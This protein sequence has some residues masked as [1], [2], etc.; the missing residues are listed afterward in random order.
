MTQTQSITTRI[1]TNIPSIGAI[2]CIA[3]CAANYFFVGGV[4]ISLRATTFLA[5]TIPFAY[6][7]SN[8]FLVLLWVRQIMRRV[9]GWWYTRVPA[10]ITYAAVTILSVFLPARQNDP[11]L[12]LFY[13]FFGQG[14]GAGVVLMCCIS[15]IMGYL[16]VYVARTTLRAL[17]LIIAIYVILGCAG[18]YNFFGSTLL[19]NMMDWFQGYWIGIVEYMA[20][21]VYHI[22]Q[23]ALVT[24]VILLQERLRPN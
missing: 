17:M 8:T 10:I 2:A 9:P 5:W 15:M 23:I 7:V 24:R 1:Y 12:V 4:P 11:Y 18:I 13:W 19:V 3:L 20:W 16:R 22:G 6:Y 21:A 14:V